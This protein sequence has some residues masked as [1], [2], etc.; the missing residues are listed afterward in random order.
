MQNGIVKLY[1]NNELP[2]AGNYKIMI[3]DSIKGWASFNYPREESEMKF[4]NKEN[5]LKRFNAAGFTSLEILDGNQKE[6]GNSIAQLD[7]GKPIWKY[8]IIAALLFFLLEILLIRFMK[9]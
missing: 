4:E 6:L 5:L 7:E 2:K 3:G 8:F 9:S 1:V